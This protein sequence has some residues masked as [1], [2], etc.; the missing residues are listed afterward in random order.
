MADAAARAAWMHQN[1]DSDLQYIMQ[2]AGVGEHVQYNIGQHY[3]TVKRFSSM[4]DDR[5]GLRG[6]LRDDYGMQ[7]DSAANRASIAA[8]VTAWDAAKYAWEEEVKFRQEA[9]TL[10]APRPL[11]HTDRTAMLRALEQNR[12]E[13][14]GEREQPSTEYIALLLE[15]VEQ[16]EIKAHPLDEITS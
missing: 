11:P 10:G 14:V 3:R 15:E 6:A 8:V 4:A 9:K 7:P 2:E 5:A 16:D 1:V 12:G 13:E